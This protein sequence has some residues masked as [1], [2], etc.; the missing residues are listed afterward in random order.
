MLGVATAAQAGVAVLTQGLTGL[1]PTL[2]EQFDLSLGQTGAL[3]TVAPLGLGATLFAWGWLSD[4]HDERVVIATGLIAGGGVMLLTPLVSSL[5]AFALMLFAASALAASGN[6]G[7]GRAVMGWFGPKERATALGLR[8]MATP[9]AAAVAI[10][11]TPVL[12]AAGGLELVLLALGGYMIAAGVVAAVVL[13]S[14]ASPAASEHADGASLLRNKRLQRL[15][16][17]GWLLSTVQMSWVVYA[18]LFLTRHEHLAIGS[19]ALLVALMQGCGAAARVVCG[20]WSDRGLRRIA[21]LRQIALVIAVC[22]LATGAA[23]DA[24]GWLA[25]PVMLF[26]GVAGMC[27]N[28]LGITA[29]GELGGMRQAGAAI[30]LYITVLLAGAAIGPVLFGL[31]LELSWG[32]AFAAAALPALLAWRLLAPLDERAQLR[33]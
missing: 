13:R 10:A 24:P 18:M 26:A 25:I 16:V 9:L 11:L 21:P 22:A 4:R 19:A 14:P 6:A 12:L 7:G 17:G 32:L 33:T 2:Q 1:G 5:W 31:C 29:A 15:A 20:R 8:Q 3:L 23:V 30:G 27:W 28:G